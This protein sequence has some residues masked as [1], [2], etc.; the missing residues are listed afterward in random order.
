MALYKFIRNRDIY[1]GAQTV[2]VEKDENDNVVK[3]ISIGEVCDLSQREFDI[4]DSFAIL[5]K[6]SV[7]AS[8]KNGKVEDTNNENKNILSDKA[9]GRD[10]KE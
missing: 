7:D 8:S 1:S 9:S 6:I 4:L 10:K 3:S 5:E 2:I